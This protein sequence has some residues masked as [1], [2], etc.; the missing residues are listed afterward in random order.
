VICVTG[1]TGHSGRHFLQELIRHDYQEPVRCVV[2]VSSDTSDLDN[3]GLKIE[4]VYG[5]LNDGQFVDSCLEGVDTVMHLYNIRHSPSIVDAAIKNHVKRAVLVHTTG[6]YSKHKC[7]S[8][9]YQRIEADVIKIASGRIDL[10]ILRPTMIY[11]DMRDRNLSKLI[12]GID[13]YWVFP[14]ID[15]GRNLIQP[16]NARDLGKAYYDVLTNP[17]K[18][19]NTTYDLSG[20]EP[21]QLIEVLRQISLLLGRKTR[22]VNVPMWL[23]LLSARFLRIITLRKVDIVEK[24]LRMGENRNYSHEAAIHDFGYSPMPFDE[25]VKIEVAEY[26]KSKAKSN[27]DSRPRETLCEDSHTPC[28]NLP[29]TGRSP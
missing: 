18:T 15:N 24:I 19:S 8:S 22:F 27:L 2:R 23:A 14:V 12:K 3:S 6:I 29:S 1:I 16:V 26:L 10:T 11:G 4:K 5:D 17:D 28:H 20:N 7:A 9:E 25:G 13:R 21:L